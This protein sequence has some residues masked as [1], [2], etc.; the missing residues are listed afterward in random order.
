MPKEKVV[1]R[2]YSSDTVAAKRIQ[3]ILV[4]ALSEAGFLDSVV[5][6]YQDEMPGPFMKVP[7]RVVSTKRRLRPPSLPA[8]SV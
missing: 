6:I 7:E 1:V 8:Q 4:Y 2:V 5:R 3:K